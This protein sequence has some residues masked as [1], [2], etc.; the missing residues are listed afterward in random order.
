MMCLAYQ[1]DDRM[2]LWNL[3][4]DVDWRQRFWHHRRCWAEAIIP[5]A[6]HGAL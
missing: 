5:K 4:N 6:C 3:D 1:Y 2:D